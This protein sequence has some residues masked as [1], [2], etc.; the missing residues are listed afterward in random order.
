MAHNLRSEPKEIYP[1]LE[2]RRNKRRAQSELMEGIQEEVSDVEAHSEEETSPK[3]KPIEIDAPVSEGE[4]SAGTDT[5]PDDLVPPNQQA[6]TPIVWNTYPELPIGYLFHRPPPH[7]D[8]TFPPLERPQAIRAQ[9]NPDFDTPHRPN[10]LAIRPRQALDFEDDIFDRSFTPPAESTPEPQSTPDIQ[11]SPE[12]P[13]EIQSPPGSISP[14]FD[15]FPEIFTSPETNS[16]P[17]IASPQYNDPPMEAQ[18]PPEIQSPPRS[19]SPPLDFPPLPPGSPPPTPPSPPLSPQTELNELRQLERQ[20]AQRINELQNELDETRDQAILALAQL[21]PTQFH[22]T[23][24]ESSRRF[25]DKFKTIAN[26]QGWNDDKLLR[27]VPVYLAGIAELWYR[28][29]EQKPQTFDEFETLLNNQF[30]NPAMRLIGKQQFRTIIQGEKETVHEFTGR[31]IGT[32]D[33]YDIEPDETRDQFLAG[34]RVDIKKQVYTLEPKT[35]EDAVKT[36]VLAEA[37]MLPVFSNEQRAEELRQQIVQLRW[38][39]TKLTNKTRIET[40]KDEILSLS[41]AELPDE[42]RKQELHGQLAEIIATDEQVGNRPAEPD[43]TLTKNNR[44]AEL[45][46]QVDQLCEVV[47]AAHQPGRRNV[48][49]RNTN[50][51]EKTPDHLPDGRTPPYLNMRPLNGKPLCNVDE[52]PGH[53]SGQSN[54]RKFMSNENA[55][56]LNELRG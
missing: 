33:E 31:I 23:G 9:P 27:T 44:I 29:L 26:A 52:K 7:R 38:T 48:H 14:P 20:N 1:G 47:A 12:A 22:G 10:T 54:S 41:R 43:E 18:S 34:L 4:Y 13:P 30:R 21:T 46:H 32:A 5:T 17:E 50:Q 15:R 40:I 2:P 28:G 42:N 3:T 56:P 51:P 16:P 55:Y 6:Q 24:H 35:I 25:I 37:A 45:Q 39:L 49:R 8:P 36:A 19:P 11:I 53:Y